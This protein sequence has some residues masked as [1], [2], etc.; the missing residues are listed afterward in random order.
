MNRT[1]QRR[2]LAIFSKFVAIA[3]GGLYTFIFSSLHLIEIWTV[4]PDMLMAAFIYLEVG[5]ILRIRLGNAN[6][7]TF[8]I[9]RETTRVPAHHY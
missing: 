4:T 6:W 7:R 8:I 3:L 1:F 2:W 5:R 9:S